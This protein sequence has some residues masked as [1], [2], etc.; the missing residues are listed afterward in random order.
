MRCA[1]ECSVQIAAAS[2]SARA[3]SQP[4]AASSVRTR[5]RSSPAAFSVK[6]IAAMFR[7]G[8]GDPEPSPAASA[9]TRSTRTA[10]LPLP[11]PASTN[12]VGR[13][14][15]GSR[16]ARGRIGRSRQGRHRTGRAARHVLRA[17]PRRLRA[18]RGSRRARAPA[19]LRSHSRQRSAVPSPSGSQYWHETNG[20]GPGGGGFATKQP[21]SIAVDDGA[22]RGV[23]DLVD[24]RVDVVAD[25]AVLAPADEPVR[26]FD[27][28]VGRAERGTGR[29]R[30]DRELQTVSAGDRV[31]GPEPDVRL[32]RSRSC[33]RSRR[34]ARRRGR[35]DRPS[36]A[37]AAAGR[38]TS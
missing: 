24:L 21:A 12:S 6:V 38:R 7:I 22:H 23:E 5:S 36:R 10:V 31:L 4:R 29:V 14:R 13:D 15:R 27:R 20:R 30:V 8:T 37:A 32:R 18:A 17:P 2:S 19:Y 1:N 28:R 9:T 3:A 11:A 16:R 34:A 26:R 25:P 33:S 35:P